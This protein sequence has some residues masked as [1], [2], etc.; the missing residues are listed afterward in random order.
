ML[1]YVDADAVRRLKADA[2][3]KVGETK[4]LCAAIERKVLS[5]EAELHQAYE[6]IT[7]A[8]AKGKEGGNAG[9]FS[10]DLESIRSKLREYLHVVK[11]VQEAQEVS[12]QEISRISLKAAG[13]YDALLN[14]KEEAKKETILGYGESLKEGLKKVAA[15]TQSLNEKLKSA[16]DIKAH[17]QNTRPT[18]EAI[19]VSLKTLGDSSRS[20]A[21]AYQAANAEANT[22]LDE[23]IQL[24][25][26][27]SDFVA[28]NDSIPGELGTVV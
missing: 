15:L 9:L 3:A 4:E 20:M 25:S 7:Q 5:A 19:H 11:E 14:G 22:L 28:A 13:A 17:L 21:S 27:Y 18:I 16:I 8:Q 24:S 26:F 1:E 10:F 2:A 12:I 23:L 6:T